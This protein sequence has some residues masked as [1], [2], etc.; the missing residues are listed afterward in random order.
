MWHKALTTAIQNQILLHA[1][2]WV[3]KGW[4]TRNVCWLAIVLKIDGDG[5][6][7]AAMLAGRNDRH[8]GFKLSTIVKPNQQQ[9]QSNI[10]TVFLPTNIDRVPRWFL[11]TVLTTT[12]L[13]ACIHSHACEFSNVPVRVT[14]FVQNKI[15]FRVNSKQI[16]R[17]YVKHSEWCSRRSR[18]I[19]KENK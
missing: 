17:A 6:A 14:I 15:R 3:R 8:G 16:F 9:R 19:Q 11:P 5:G 18:E 12:I 10:N 7:S 13:P 1:F 2:Y 4:R